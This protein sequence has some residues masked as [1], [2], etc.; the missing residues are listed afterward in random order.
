MTKESKKALVTSNNSS[1]SSTISEFQA[2]SYSKTGKK[3]LKLG[4]YSSENVINFDR[5]N[6]KKYLKNQ[7]LNPRVYDVINF[8]YQDKGIYYLNIC[9]TGKE[10]SDPYK[11]VYL[12][13]AIAS[14]EGKF[15][16]IIIDVENINGTLVSY[17]AEICDNILLVTCPNQNGLNYVANQTNRIKKVNKDANIYVLLNKVKTNS[18]Y[19][20]DKKYE[21][22]RYGETF[23]YS[24]LENTVRDSVQVQRLEKVYVDSKYK[25]VKIKAIDDLKKVSYEILTKVFKENFYY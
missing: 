2:D 16:Y 17:L 19:H 21:I 3:V 14:L 13:K 1:G 24:L 9:L 6:G 5:C 15:E 7:Y 8:I 11:I 22:N 4:I 12:K 20:E 23:G 18:K 25:Y 10:A